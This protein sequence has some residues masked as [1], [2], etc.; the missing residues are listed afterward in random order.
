MLI[1]KFSAL[2]V[3][4]LF[5]GVHGAFAEDLDIGLSTS[6]F[7]Q[8][9]ERSVVDGWQ[10]ST[11]KV[12]R[13]H[14]IQS[15]AAQMVEDGL[16]VVMLSG[17]EENALCSA[18]EL[19][20]ASTTMDLDLN[21]LTSPANCGVPFV[22]YGQTIGY[23]PNNIDRPVGLVDFFDT[24]GLPGTR[25]LHEDPKGLLEMAL[26]ADGVASADVYAV[27]ATDQGLAR[28]FGKLDQVKPQIVWSQTSTATL[29]MLNSGDVTL[30][31]TWSGPFNDAVRSGAALKA[32]KDFMLVEHSYLAVPI[33][34]AQKDGAASFLKYATSP[35]GFEA[36]VK[37]T[38]GNFSIPTDQ[39]V[40]KP[41]DDDLIAHACS[42]GTCA[43]PGVSGDCKSSCCDDLDGVFG[44]FELDE[45]FWEQNGA[46][47]N[48]AFEDWRTQ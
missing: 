32:T 46:R 20:Q 41:L 42:Q 45:G 38:D 43:C 14:N 11:A 6:A 18:G 4:S 36:F 39:V 31:M 8:L 17:A 21:H 44:H 47:L 40:Q 3:L 19:A 34:S 13:V 15:G 48:L 1:P 24:A 10:D 22:S 12:A 35:K 16:D 30:A 26:L 28:A 27:L 5:C 2:C 37:G 25:A 7:S 29:N 23:N 9:Y 33:R